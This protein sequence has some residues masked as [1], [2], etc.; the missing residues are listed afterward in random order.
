MTI[1]ISNQAPARIN[2]DVLDGARRAPVHRGP[3]KPKPFARAA[4]VAFAAGPK[5]LLSNEE[6]KWMGKQIVDMY[7]Q[8]VLADD[9]REF[10]FTAV[11]DT[12]Y[13][14]TGIDINKLLIRSK[15]GLIQLDSYGN[16]KP[17][18]AIPIKSDVALERGLMH[19]LAALRSAPFPLNPQHQIPGLPVRR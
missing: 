3:E 10:K 8:K 11:D 5:R 16:A 18:V 7:R 6:R 9:R 2:P 17:N 15:H 1:S 14:M 12:T 19:T 4:A 13:R